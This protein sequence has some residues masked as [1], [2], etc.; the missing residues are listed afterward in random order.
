MYSAM[1]PPFCHH[2]FT[3]LSF[4]CAPSIHSFPSSEPLATADP[5]TVCIVLP[6]PEY[7]RVGMVQSVTCSRLSSFSWQYALKLP[8]CLF[9]AEKYSI[10]EYC[11][12]TGLCLSVHLQ[13]AILISSKFWWLWIKLNIH[14]QD[15]TWLL[16]G[17]VR[18]CLVL[19][20][21]AKLFFQS[22]YT[23]CIPTSSEWFFPVAYLT[24]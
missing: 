11:G 1:Y 18:V 3:A 19:K 23:V 22:S 2:G 16:D 10:V 14:V 4:P 9:I 15:V 5:V 17:V 12:C 7:H 24:F 20:E 21:I 8:P 13:K 6:F